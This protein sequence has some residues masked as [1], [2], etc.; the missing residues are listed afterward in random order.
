[1]CEYHIHAAVSRGRAGR[2]EFTASTSGFSLSS[3]S[4]AQVSKQ[5]G[6]GGKFN[7][8]RKRGLP[9]NSGAG[10]AGPHGEGAT[11]VV[12]GKAIHMRSDGEVKTF[13]DE[14]LSEKLG[15]GRAGKKKRKMEEREAEEA[16]SRLLEK[17]G[18]N[19]T[20]GAKYLAK[21]GKKFAP[22]LNGRQSNGSSEAEGVLELDRKRPF[23]V[24]A[25]RRIGFDPTAK[26][27][28]RDDEDK[29]K[30]VGLALDKLD[31]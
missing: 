21:L 23:G 13:G 4:G 22:A 26:P 15:R 12:G 17:D 10:T 18:G 20:T 29:S 9:P 11:Y 14:H 16:L 27:G 19:G 7:P 8:Y 6:P 28:Q 25:V 31:W 24:N 3:H 2:A 1:M 30:R 5:D